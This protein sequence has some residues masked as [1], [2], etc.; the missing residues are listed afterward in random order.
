MRGQVGIDDFVAYLRETIGTRLLVDVQ[1][2]TANNNIIGDG[3]TW[4]TIDG[5]TEI[6]DVNSEYAAGTGVFTASQTAT[7]A[8][9]TQIVVEANLPHISQIQSRLLRDGS[10]IVG[11][12]RNDGGNRTVADI[13]WTWSG[14][15]E[16]GQT[17]EMQMLGI[18]S[19]G[20]DWDVSILSPLNRMYIWRLGL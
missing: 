11:I 13:A 9:H 7:Y 12:R 3:S 14:A 4:A 10:A 6:V 20:N 5:W 15:L 2:G 17:L 19:T 18:G 1:L 8:W 16:A